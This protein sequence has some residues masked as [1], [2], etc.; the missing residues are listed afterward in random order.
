VLLSATPVMTSANFNLA[1][2]IA[3]GRVPALEATCAH[4]A[5][6]AFTISLSRARSC[7]PSLNSGGGRSA[8]TAA[9]TLP[10]HLPFP[11]RSYGT[12]APSCRGP[13]FYHLRMPFEPVPC[14]VRHLPTPIGTNVHKPSDLGPFEGVGVFIR[15]STTRHG[16]RWAKAHGVA[17]VRNDRR[18]LTK[19]PL[20]GAFFQELKAIAPRNHDCNRAADAGVQRVAGREAG[21]GLGLVRGLGQACLIHGPGVLPTERCCHVGFLS[22]A[23]TMPV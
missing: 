5:S 20:P 8:T 19:P 16:P 7:G 10:L 3:R 6:Y 1:A 2:T 14:K 11:R 22:L 9:S 23:Q 18:R 17:P 21:L 13:F 4:A 15:C 12:L